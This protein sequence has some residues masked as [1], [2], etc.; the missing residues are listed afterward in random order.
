MEDAFQKLNAFTDADL[1]R[2]DKL[3]LKHSTNSRSSQI[4]S[5]VI[6]KEWMSVPMLNEQNENKSRSHVEI[7][8]F[9]E[10]VLKNVDNDL[11][12]NLIQESKEN[13]SEKN[14][15]KSEEN[16]KEEFI[17]SGYFPLAAQLSPKSSG[18][19]VT[20]KDVETDISLNP[21]KYVQ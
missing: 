11:M 12:T 4:K 15:Q 20:K 2:K 19:N 16:K 14:E 5:Q 18:V 13:D 6:Q 21:F 8:G 3:L 1:S 10:V 17:Q 9:S 7:K